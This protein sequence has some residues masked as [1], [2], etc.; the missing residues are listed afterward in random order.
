MIGTDE[1]Q[2]YKIDDSIAIAASTLEE[3][4]EYF[5]FI[6]GVKEKNL[7]SAVDYEIIPNSYKVQ[8]SSINSEWVP[9]SDIIKEGWNGKPFIVFMVDWSE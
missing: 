6:S 2:I 7:S 1:V 3:A 5:Q 8:Y 9:V 4:V